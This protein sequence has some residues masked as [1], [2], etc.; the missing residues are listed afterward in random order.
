M[1]KE[2]AMTLHSAASRSTVARRALIAIALMGMAGCTSGPIGPQVPA[3]IVFFTPFSADL[4][5]A[6]KA[7]IVDAGRAAVTAP[8]RRVVVAGYSDS[9]G[10]TDTNKTLSQLRAQIVADGLVEQGVSRSRISLE[11]KGPQAGDPG[12]ESR[13]VAIEIN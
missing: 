10:A 13:R 2:S 7:V 6:A 3:Y 5:D 11:P 12:V 9:Q 1:T 8:N 4:D